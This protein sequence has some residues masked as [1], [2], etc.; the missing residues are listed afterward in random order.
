VTKE[1]T[2]I[3][4]RVIIKKPDVAFK[5]KIKN[6]IWLKYIKGSFNYIFEIGRKIIIN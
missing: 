1:V 3:V 6:Y 2:G 5:F 4:K